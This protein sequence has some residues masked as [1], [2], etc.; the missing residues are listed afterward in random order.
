MRY[1]YI[2][3]LFCLSQHLA[4]QSVAVGLYHTHGHEE[5]RFGFGNKSG[6]HEWHLFLEAFINPNHG[7]REGAV[8]HSRRYAYDSLDYV[9]AGGRYAYHFFKDAKR[10]SPYV[11]IESQLAPTGLR[12]RLQAPDGSFQTLN[13]RST[14]FWDN[15]LMAGCHWNF[16]E[17]WGIDFGIGGGYTY[18]F[19]IPNSFTITTKYGAPI[20]PVFFMGGT[21]RYTFS[22]SSFRG[23]PQ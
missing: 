4:A 9:G 5:F 21:V 13:F 2:S 18:I 17:Q 6:H 11:A 8:F 14:R 7:A 12:L 10:F 1:L 19:G 22:W 16:N 23:R 3:L 20:D 15:I